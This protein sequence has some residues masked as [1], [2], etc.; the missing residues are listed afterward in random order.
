[1]AD[2]GG[3]L[4][5]GGVVGDHDDGFVE[6]AV[7]FA[8]E[9]HDVVRGLFVEVAGG[10]VG[11][12]EVGVHGDGAGNGNALLLSARELVG[13]VFG[14]VGKPDD[15]KCVFDL[16]AAFG[17]RERREHEREFD[18]LVG[19]E[20]GDEVVELEDEADVVGAP[21]REL[22]FAHCADVVAE[23][24]H[25]AAAWLVNAGYDIEQGC[26]ARTGGTHERHELAAVDVE[27]EVIEHGD[28][29][30]LARVV[31]CKVAD[32]DGNRHDAMGRDSD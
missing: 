14:A 5:G 12:D 3:A 6:V 1:M 11:N 24:I 27:R 29:V 10:F 8:E 2:N 17:F 15:G 19:G 23:H 7:E 22:R 32:A 13:R 9:F 21:F 16:L 18:V 20:H 31:L 26:F 25:S 4:G 30:V 28:G